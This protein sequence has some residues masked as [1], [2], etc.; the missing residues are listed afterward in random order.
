M[1]DIE[2]VEPPVVRR[3][4]P[5]RGPSPK[6]VA[7]VEALRA[8]PGEWALVLRGAT[9]SAATEISHGTLLAYRPAGSFEATAR[10]N[11]DRHDI[12]ARYVGEDG[13]HR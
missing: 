7:I 4:R 13:E 2:F 1:T 11:G 9:R 12:Y 8:T 10:K 5:G 3:L 6:H